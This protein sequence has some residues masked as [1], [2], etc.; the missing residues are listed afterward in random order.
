MKEN[1]TTVRD[2]HHYFTR[3]SEYNF[4]VP[5][6][7]GQQ[8]HT[9]YYNGIKDWNSLP[10]SIKSIKNTE[11]FKSRVK[12]ILSENSSAESRNDFIKY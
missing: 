2:C 11:A 1:F 12:T 5:P 10:V 7:K 6:V 8:F 3:S 9:F 4:F